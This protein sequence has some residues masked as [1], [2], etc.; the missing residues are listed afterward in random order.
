MS[1]LSV[2]VRNCPETLNYFKEFK[3]RLE[4]SS[5][6]FKNPF[7]GQVVIIELKNK[8]DLFAFINISP[9]YPPFFLVGLA[10]LVLGFILKGG[11]AWHWMTTV[12]VVFLS[13]GFFWSPVFFFLMLRLALRKKGYKKTVLWLRNSKAL[14]RVLFDAI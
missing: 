12:G 8:K 13:L 2:L 1:V 6:F 10:P 14:K 5:D 9:S 7:K 3:A 4:D 11:L